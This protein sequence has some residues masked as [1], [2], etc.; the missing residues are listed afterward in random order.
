MD[1]IHTYPLDDSRQHALA[2]FQCPCRPL[3]MP[4]EG[5]GNYTY[6]VIHNSFDGREAGEHDAISITCPVCGMTSYNLND[7]K[8]GYCG[9]CCKFTGEPRVV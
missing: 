6:H 2:G 4:Y 7:V 9:N 1:A 8:Y 5:E 3:V